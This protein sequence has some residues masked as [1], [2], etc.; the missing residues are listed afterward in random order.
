[1]LRNMAMQRNVKLV[2]LS[3][4]LINAADLLII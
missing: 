4:Q 3:Q 2:D 1:L